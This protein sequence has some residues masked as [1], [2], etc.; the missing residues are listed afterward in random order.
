[1]NNKSKV[2]RTIYLSE[3]DEQAIERIRSEMQFST[4]ARTIRYAIQDMIRR[5]KNSQNRVGHREELIATVE[6]LMEYCKSIEL[7]SKYDRLA[8]I[9]QCR[10]IDTLIA[11]VK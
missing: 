5:F 3:Q 11:K 8:I 10:A 4:K 2:K 9:K 1:M 7:L 6:A